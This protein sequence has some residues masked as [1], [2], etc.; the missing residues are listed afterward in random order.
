MINILDL[1][2][3]ITDEQAIHSNYDGDSDTGDGSI[4]MLFVRQQIYG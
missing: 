2:D 1:I 4:F 3:G